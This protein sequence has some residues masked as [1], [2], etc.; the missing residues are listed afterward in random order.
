MNNYPNYG[1]CFICSI[2]RDLNSVMIC[3]ECQKKIDEQKAK[4]INPP[5][6]LPRNN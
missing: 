1:A 6:E 5:K 4:P 3:R 2:R